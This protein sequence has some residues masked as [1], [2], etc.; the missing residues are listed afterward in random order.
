[1]ASSPDFVTLVAEACRLAGQVTTRKMFGEYALYLDGV[2]VGLI[3]DNRFFVKQTGAGRTILGTPGEAA[4]YPGARP[5]FVI[6]HELDDPELMAQIIRATR[7][8][9]GSPAAASAKRKRP[10][11]TK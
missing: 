10:A 3:C 11:R 1:M 7:D 9:L 5:A 8:E 2:L 6:E 4:P